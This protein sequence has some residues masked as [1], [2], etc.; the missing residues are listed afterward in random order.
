[1]TFF[2][3][4]KKLIFFP[5]TLNRP[6]YQKINSKNYQNKKNPIKKKKT[7]IAAYFYDKPKRK[8]KEFCVKTT[9]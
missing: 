8:D 4:F 3:N 9:N 6:Q 1:M 5:A 2:F 7:D